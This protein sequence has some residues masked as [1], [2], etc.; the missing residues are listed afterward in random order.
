MKDDTHIDT[1]DPKD[2]PELRGLQTNRAALQTSLARIEGRA[3]K[4][5]AGEKRN[6]QEIEARMKEIDPDSVREPAKPSGKK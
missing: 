6:L 2:N 3:P 5:V 1:T 4:V